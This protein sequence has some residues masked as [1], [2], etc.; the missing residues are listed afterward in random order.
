MVITMVTNQDT[1]NVTIGIIITIN[2]NDITD[3]TIPSTLTDTAIVM[4]D[5]TTIDQ[6]AIVNLD[7]NN[8][9]Q[10]LRC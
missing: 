3:I 7:I 9:S 1:T 5:I 4:E 10:I 6:E 2:P 8:P